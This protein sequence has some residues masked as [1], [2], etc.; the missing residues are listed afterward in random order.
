[1]IF[2]GKRAYNTKC[3]RLHIIGTVDSSNQIDLMVIET[4][5]FAI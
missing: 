2:T 1:M 5:T 4:V 3:I